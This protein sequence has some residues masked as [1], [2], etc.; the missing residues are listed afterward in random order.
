[1][2]VFAQNGYYSIVADKLDRDTLWVRARIEGDIAKVWPDASVVHTP[3]ADYAY[4]S[5]LSRQEVAVAIGKAVL[6]ISYSNFK[7]SITDK[8]RSPFYLRCWHAM[9]EMQDVLGAPV[10]VKPR[11]G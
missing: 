3:E 4:R 7:D 8:R 11:A 9:W 2:W 6:G 10:K 1:M 5:A